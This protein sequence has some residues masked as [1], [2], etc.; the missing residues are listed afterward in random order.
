M[1][2]Y[3]SGPITGLD[4]AEAFENFEKAEKYFI[5]KSYEV[6]NPMKLEH[7]HDLSWES[8]MRVDLKAMLD[9]DGIALLDN[10]EQSKGAQVEHRLAQ[11]LKMDIWIQPFQN[12]GSFVKI[13]K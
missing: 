5:S 12:N 10:W 8:Y 11:D 1:K 7:N 4:E 3:I 9:C 13:N 2:I 6:I